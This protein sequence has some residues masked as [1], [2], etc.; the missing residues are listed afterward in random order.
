[1]ICLALAA[2]P[3]AGEVL[4]VDANLATGQ[5]DGT[6]WENAY[7][8]G[9]G[10]V[11]AISDASSGDEIWAAAGTY[12][13]TSG[14]SR[15]AAVLLKNGVRIL[16]GFN[17]T[18]TSAGQRDY[19]TN[20]TILSGDLLGNDNGAAG[21]TDNSYNVVDA[22]F[23]NVTAILDG[24]TITGG[25]ANHPSSML[26][27]VG[28]GM[29][30]RDGS[31]P[32][33]RNCRFTNNRVTFGGGAIYFRSSSPTIDNCIFED[34]IGGAFGGAWDMFN[35][36][37][38]T[39]RNCI[40]RN[41]RAA[42]AGGVETFQNCSPTFEDCVFDNNLATGTTGGGGMFIAF[43]GTPSFTRCVYMNNSARTGGAIY[44]DT[45]SARFNACIF[46][47]NETTLA[48][49][50]GG[51]TYG[52][53]SA[54]PQYRDCLFV[55]NSAGTGAAMRNVTGNSPQIFNCTYVDNVASLTGGGLS[56]ANANPNIQNSIFWNNSDNNGTVT[57]SQINSTGTSNPN[58]NYSNIQ[59]GW[60]GNGANN[61]N[62]DPAFVD[63]G[64][65]NW[66]LTLNS[67]CANAGNPG[68]VPQPDETDLDG[69]A[70]VLCDR[71]DMGAYESGMGDADCDLDVDVFDFEAFIDCETGPDGGVM[72]DCE[73]FDD[74]GDDDIDWT[75]AQAF[76]LVVTLP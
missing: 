67:P 48:N 43:G 36:C 74:D 57:T 70:R 6:S 61:L 18:E 50:Q 37:S 64:S 45:V 72:V 46:I 12:Q 28:G 39:V 24:F 35:N 38:P 54:S 29:I 59:G 11:S 76:W 44:N 27:Q 58:V 41:N 26:D 63:A 10:L 34:N 15:F 23:T 20:E 5:D 32:S 49:G 47:N 33:I 8:G 30:C 9:A 22:N 65:G 71:V 16:G 75:D 2:A 56:N 17:G 53:N 4:Y 62:I 51:G 55:G 7:Q 14:T 3:A 25:N 73:M 68:F 21:L 42:R 31:N 52:R 19:Q 13:P 1:M 66:R 69:H 40:F 60:T